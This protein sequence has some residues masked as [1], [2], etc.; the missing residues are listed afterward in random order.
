MI[1]S[2][3]S[4]LATKPWVALEDDK[5][6]FTA[7]AVIPVLTQKLADAGGES[8]ES[9]IDSVSAKLTTEKLIGMNKSFDVDKEDAKD[10]AKTF[11]TD[12][13]LL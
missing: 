5:K 7:D 9:L 3:D 2:S 1:F 10:I 6:L 13:G 12:A 4:S 11:L 8:F